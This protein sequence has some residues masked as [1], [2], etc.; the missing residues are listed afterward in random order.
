MSCSPSV[1]IMF[2]H[3]NVDAEDADS[4]CQQYTVIWDSNV[5]DAEMFAFW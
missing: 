4:E 5:V 3:R 1:Y 2:Q